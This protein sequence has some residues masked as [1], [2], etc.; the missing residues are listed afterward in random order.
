MHWLTRSRGVFKK[1][2]TPWFVRH[3]GINMDEAI[4]TDW[5]KYPD[6]NSFFTRALKPEARPL[7]IGEQNLICPVDGSVSQAGRINGDRIFQAKGHE[8]SLAS[9]LGGSSNWCD[10]FEN[11][12]FA[13]LYLSPKDYHRIHMPLD[14]KLLEVIHV[15]GRLFSVNPATTRA[16]PGLFAR[17]ERVVCIFETEAGPMAMVLVGAIFVA[18]IETVWQG[19]I[20]P[21]AG[22]QIQRWDHREKEIVLKQGEEMGRFNMGSTVILLYPADKMNWADSIQPDVPVKMG[23]LLGGLKK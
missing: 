20:T 16:I 12:E 14:G 1:L 23:Q 7:V 3:F 4:E 21:P 6:F 9:L 15:P 10:A 19:V 13:T 2:F 22:K 18:S 5:R 8:Y 17:N 11:G